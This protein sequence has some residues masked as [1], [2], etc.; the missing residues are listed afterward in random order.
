MRGREELVLRVYVDHR[1][2]SHV[3][4]MPLELFSEYGQVLKKK[5]KKEAEEIDGR[6]ERERVGNR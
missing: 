5:K 3:T 2:P 6:I 1:A 4:L